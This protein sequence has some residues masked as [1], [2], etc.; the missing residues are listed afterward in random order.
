MC[1]R[2]L[3]VKVPA[4]INFW[5]EVLGRR[6]DG[7]HE[8]SS[9]MLPIGIYDELHLRVLPEEG[10]ILECDQP[11]IPRDR[12]NLAWRAAEVFYE[13]MDARPALHIEIKKS[14]PMAAGLGGGSADA[15]GVLVGLSTLYPG[16]VS[17]EALHELAARLGADIPFFLYRK[18]ALATGIGERLERVSGIPEYPLLLL[19]PPL[20]V[21]TAWVYNSLKLTR[22]G[23]R[24]KVPRLMADP[25]SL[26][27]FLQND[28]ESVTLNA[29]PVLFHLKEWLVE[30][31][32]LGALMSGSGPTV[33][34]VFTSTETAGAA[35]SA[36]RSAWPDAWVACTRVLGG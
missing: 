17:P 23:S 30:Q 15:A 16:K 8:L 36:A 33:F 27:E 32:A 6:V 22:G 10:I 31:G 26:E 24:I 5:L 34:G 20:T 28:L 25:W 4:K 11:E 18:P 29:V 7:Y 19:K 13:A 1:R 14:I 12:S 9:L 21:S 2:A 35:E 3:R